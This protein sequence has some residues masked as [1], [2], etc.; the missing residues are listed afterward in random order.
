MD[1]N[2]FS[3]IHQDYCRLLLWDSFPRSIRHTNARIMFSLGSLNKLFGVEHVLLKKVQLF[4]ILFVPF[5]VLLHHQKKN[6][7]TTSRSDKDLQ[8]RNPALAH[9]SDPP[10]C[11]YIH[12]HIPA[13]CCLHQHETH[14]ARNLLNCRHLTKHLEKSYEIKETTFTHWSK[15]SPLLLRGTQ[16]K[17]RA[18]HH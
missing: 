2:N 15:P 8:N 11:H 13:I 6:P 5:H 10:S 16:L 12:D 7:Q 18:G 1:K 17:Y 9:S 14:Q 4:S 3:S